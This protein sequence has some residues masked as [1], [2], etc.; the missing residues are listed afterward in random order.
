MAWHLFSLWMQMASRYCV[1]VNILNKKMWAANKQWSSNL[2][3]G[4]AVKNSI[5]YK[6][7]VIK[8]NKQT[9]TWTAAMAIE[10]L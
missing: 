7:N 6:G 5:P 8:G 9:E 10:K 3:V 1:A 2:A 4:R